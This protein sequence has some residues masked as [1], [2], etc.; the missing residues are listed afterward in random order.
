[1]SLQKYTQADLLAMESLYRRQ[2]MNSIAGVKTANLVATR[3][4]QGQENV[5]VFNSFVHLGANPPHI[6]FIM[7]PTTVERHTFDNIQAT[8]FYTIN[9]IHAAFIEAAHQSSAKYPKEVSEFEA[10]GLQPVYRG[11]FWAPYVGESLVSLGVKFK[12]AIFISSNEVYLVIGEILE[13]H[14][15]EGLLQADGFVDLAKAQTVGIGGLD[16]Y[17]GLEELARF[18]YARP[19]QPLKKL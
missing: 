13:I 6:G 7:R 12:E 10:C 17:Y 3:D 1:M 14:I 2:L 5:A 15:E 19:G 8:G 4:A 18:A 11:D 9:H 16:T